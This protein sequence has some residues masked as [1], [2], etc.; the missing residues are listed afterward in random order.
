MMTQCHD[1]N[2]NNNNDDDDDDD[3]DDDE[4][5][6]TADGIMRPDISHQIYRIKLAWTFVQTNA[7]TVVRTILN[8]R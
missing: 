8:A 1:C 3:D 5:D 6:D 7:R 4:N 2:N